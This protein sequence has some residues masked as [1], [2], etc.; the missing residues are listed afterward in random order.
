MVVHVQRW[1]IV[2]HYLQ[3]I[4]L[5]TDG[6]GESYGQLDLVVPSSHA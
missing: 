4:V 3:F 2:V 6:A 1:L 5:S